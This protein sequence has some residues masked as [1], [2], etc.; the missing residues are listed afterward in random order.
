MKATGWQAH[1]VRGF[2][3]GWYARS[4]VCHFRR[5]SLMPTVSTGLSRTAR[6]AQLNTSRPVDV[7]GRECRDRSRA[8]T[9]S[10]HAGL[11]SF[12]RS[13]ARS[14]IP[15]RP[16]PLDRDLLRRS[17]AYKIQEDAYSG[18]YRTTARLLKGLMAQ[19]ALRNGRILLP[20][21]IKP[22]AIL[23]RQ[24]K[25]QSHRVTVQDDGFA[26]QGKPYQMG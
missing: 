15:I 26:Y 8:R 19:F 5:T 11:L 13:G 18:L 25:G 2:L 6:R 3:P 22:G 17:I 1:S 9:A 4:S 20:R 16:R 12:A 7:R 14:S 10:I 21:R 24:W 23:V